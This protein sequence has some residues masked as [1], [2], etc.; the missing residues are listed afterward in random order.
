M[1]R[2]IPACAGMTSWWDEIVRHMDR[3][4]PYFFSA[5]TPGRG[6]P[7]IHSRN[8]PPAVET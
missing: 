7:S 1:R 5:S 8:A 4:T 3:E 2:W 6:L